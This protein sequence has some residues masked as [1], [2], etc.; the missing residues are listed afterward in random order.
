MAK[1]RKHRKPTGLVKLTKSSAKG[2]PLFRQAVERQ[3][4]QK[5]AEVN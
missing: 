5:G 3:I 4:K 2:F 1:P